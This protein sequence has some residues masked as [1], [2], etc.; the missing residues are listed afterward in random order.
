MKSR[1]NPG[2]T[3]SK[4]LDIVKRMNQ[5]NRIDTL[6]CFKA[7]ADA[8][9]LRLVN[10]AR[11]FEL[12]VNEIVETMG[13]GQSRISR[14]LKILADAGLLSPRHDGLWTF[15]STV[16]DGDAGRFLDAMAFSFDGGDFARDLERAREVQVERNRESQRFFDKVAR[17]WP[18]MKR[19]IIGDAALDRFVAR[20]IPRC[21]IAVDLGCGSGDLL[22]VLQ[23][24]ARRV[25]GVDRAP[26]ML[27]EARRRHLTHRHNGTLELRLGEL[28]HLPLRE[29]E[30]DCAVIS[31][32]LHHLAEPEKGIIE[33]A[34]ILKP[35]GTLVIIDLDAHHDETLRTRY[36]D[37][38]LGFDAALI[39]KWLARHGF[40]PQAREALAIDRGLQ[41]FLVRSRKSELKKKNQIRR[42]KS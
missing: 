25:I 8:T 20:H 21:T 1:Q 33:A 30:A 16:N 31:M 7:L 18:E 5:E 15:Y 39:E 27:E 42:R 37:R 9:R 35:G 4:Y 32:A 22:P 19:T 36:N 13:M 11:H 24:K 10:I 17:D 6:R 41:A 23:N 2:L 3:I 28:E 26:R 29:A 14:H 12:N 38:W 40:T 34:R